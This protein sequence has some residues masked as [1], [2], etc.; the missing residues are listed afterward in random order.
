[1]RPLQ[2]TVNLLEWN[3]L[4]PAPAHGGPAVAVAVRA[5][6]DTGAVEP[7]SEVNLSDHEKVEFVLGRAERPW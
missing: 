4:F 3:C 6:A 2:W 1:M 7:V 5:V